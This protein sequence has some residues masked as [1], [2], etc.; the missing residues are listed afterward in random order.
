MGERLMVKMTNQSKKLSNQNGKK[1]MSTYSIVISVMSAVVVL[2]ASWSLFQTLGKQQATMEHL[3]QAQ[4]V[5]RQ[6]VE[7]NRQAQQEFQRV[8]DSEYLAQI[9]RRDYYYSKEGEIIFDLKEEDQ[10]EI[11]ESQQ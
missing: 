4:A 9:A 10:E 7:N 1:Q 3:N 8:Q 2:G 11:S 6:A 5:N